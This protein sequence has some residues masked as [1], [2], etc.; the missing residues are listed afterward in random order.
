MGEEV[1]GD[2]GQVFLAG[3]IYFLDGLSY[4]DSLSLSFTCLYDVSYQLSEV[5]TQVDEICKRLQRVICD[6]L[7]LLLD[8]QCGVLN[9]IHVS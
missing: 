1:D 9:E 3:S 7:L 8:Q 5:C 2:V 6:Q 4:I